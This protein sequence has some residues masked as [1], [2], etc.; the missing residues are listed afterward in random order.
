MRQA[1]ISGASGFIGARLAKFLAYHGIKVY[2]LGRKKLL[3]IKPSRLQENE[4]LTYIQIDMSNISELP[5]KLKDL[6]AKLDDCVMFNFA[7]AGKRGLSDLDVEGQLNNAIWAVDAYKVSDLLKCKKF[8]HVGTME[9][10]FAESYLQKDYHSDSVYNRHLIYSIAKLS[11]RSLLKAMRSQMNTELIVV[12][13]SHVMGPNDDRDSFLRVTLKKVIEDKALEFTSGQQNFD[14]V[15]ILDCVRAFKLIGELGKDK[16]EYWVGSGQARTLREYT[17]ILVKRYAPNK[18]MQF[19]K[20]SFNDV[21][22]PL[23]TF[24]PQKLFEDT[25]FKCIQTYEDAVEE[26]YQYLAHDNLIERYDI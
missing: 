23:D 22:L 15:S 6:N 19:G 16:A 10:A 5:S 20:I 17:E 9:E 1:I 3:E 8:V 14:V 2:A 12:A 7:W 13:K 21:K 26:M 4:N 24:S 11:S 18:E 25:G